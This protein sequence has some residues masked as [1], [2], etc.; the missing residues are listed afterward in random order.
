MDDLTVQK[1]FPR[2]TLIRYAK[3]VK[4][5]SPTEQQKF[6]NRI[7]KDYDRIIDS[8]YN[9]TYRPQPLRECLIPK[10]HGEYRRIYINSDLDRVI[11]SCINEYITPGIDVVFNDNNYGFRQDRGCI[12][13]INKVL[14]SIDS[15]YVYV[16]KTDIKSYFDT[17]DQNIVRYLLS[18]YIEDKDLRKLLFR[19]ITLPVKGYK[20]KRTTGIQQGSSISP[21]LANMVLNRFDHM[22]TARGYRF[23][24]YADDI[25]ILKKSEAAARRT[26]ESV[27]HL[28]Q[29]E[30][31]LRLNEDKTV[32]RNAYEGFDLLGFTITQTPE[33]RHIV[34]MA[35]RVRNL[36][37]N[38]DAVDRMKPEEVVPKLNSIIRGWYGYFKISDLSDI[39]NVIDK[40][41]LRTIRRS[42]SSHKKVITTENLVLIR[43]LCNNQNA[44][45]G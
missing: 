45:V 3:Q 39:V 1:I 2:G 14:E 38:I 10:G 20:V 29:S 25:C 43:Y 41:A 36:L 22:L 31:N 35:S 28:L 24:R 40:E 5:H 26:L 17:I 7:I 23:I 13:A 42:E 8:L 16:V 37:E 34:P 30:F 27:K 33:G 9:D 44:P 4:K 6:V 15:G 18:H 21:L 19:F 12:M 11:L 32:I